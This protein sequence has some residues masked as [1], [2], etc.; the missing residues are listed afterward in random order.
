[1]AMNQ[2]GTNGT[3]PAVVTPERW[4]RHLPLTLLLALVVVC[5][6][7]MVGFSLV[8]WD[9][10]HHVYRNPALLEPERAPWQDA[11]LG[12]NVGYPMPVTLLTWR[13]DRALWGPSS[14]DDFRPEQ[15][16]GY[17]A[18][19]LLWVLAYAAA[20]FLL[21]RSVL[22]GPWA[23]LWAAA[24]AVLHPT[25]VEPSVWTTGR[26]DLLVGVFAMLAVQRLWRARDGGTSPWLQFGALSIIAM[27]CKPVGVL[28]LPLGLWSLWAWPRMRT[29]VAPA[30]LLGLG[31]VAGLVVAVSMVWHRALGGLSESA[32][33]LHTL[34]RASWA[35][36]YHAHLW[37]WP[38]GLRPKYVVAAPQGLSWFDA[39][40]AAVAVAL[41]LI[42]VHPRTRGRAAGLGAALALCAYA[43]VSGLVGMKRYI[44]DSYLLLPGAG[45][46]LV[47]GDLASVTSAWRFPMARKAG[48]AGVVLVLGLMSIRQAAIWQDSIELW[49]YAQRLEPGSPEV[50]R[51]LGHAYGEQGQPR[52]AIGVYG[53]CA[54]RFGPGP[55]ANN[56][57]LTAF[58]L[59]DLPLARK[60]FT[61]ILTQDP[62]DA[63]AR[64]YL[65]ELDRRELPRPPGQAEAHQKL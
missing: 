51:M 56:L 26:K 20:T 46:A 39:L 30:V 62:H 25:A 52:A 2:E 21:F 24:V 45:V 43:P 55:Y 15:G 63:R 44:A 22:A 4:R 31:L 11:W 42:V 18:S 38:V 27:G 7:Q 60:W 3:A 19:Q 36:G 23:A 58:R 10:P 28:L 50:C 57:A 9:D 59:G 32:S 40:G 5:Y 16:R 34:R 47:L 64:H 33:L 53:R 61:W 6:G 29:R 35:L 13:L 54:D 14:P 17:H 8:N 12:R 41:V 65:D 37:L 48:A 1:M 49:T